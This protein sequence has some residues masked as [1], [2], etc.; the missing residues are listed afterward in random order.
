MELAS[1]KGLGKARIAKLR[2]A[3][4]RDA[5]SLAS[6]KA[7]ELAAATGISKKLLAKWIT[8]AGRSNAV[9]SA[10][11]R[12]V[13]HVEE[14]EDFETVDVAPVRMETP[15]RF[16]PVPQ[17]LDELKNSINELTVLTKKN[18][19]ANT[20]L[21][22]KVTDMLIKMIDIMGKLQIMIDTLRKMSTMEEKILQPIDFTP[23]MTELRF[24]RQGI[25]ELYKRLDSI[26]N[27]KR[28]EYTDHLIQKVKDKF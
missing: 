10:P 28:K 1:I 5:E 19:S 11:K 14:V 6:A 16:E 13:A 2:K 9:K 18:I 24:L 3:G 20:N 8:Q 7:G 26:D 27:Y 22:I 23:L 12:P 15:K 25:E 17:N 21:Q 4:I